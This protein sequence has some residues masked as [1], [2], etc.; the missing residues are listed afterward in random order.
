MEVEDLF[1]DQVQFTCILYRS[2]AAWSVPGSLLH[3]VSG[4]MAAAIP[5][6]AADWKKERR[7]ISCSFQ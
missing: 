3:A 5:P 4:A 6:K 7:F 1:H 2:P